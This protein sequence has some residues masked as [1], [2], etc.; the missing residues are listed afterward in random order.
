MSDRDS[1]WQA[2]NL[3]RIFHAG[4]G[5]GRSVC[6]RLAKGQTRSLGD[7]CANGVRRPK[8]STT[9][10]ATLRRHEVV[11][12]HHFATVIGDSHTPQMHQDARGALGSLEN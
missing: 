8:H 12:C 4:I 3:L 2:Q 5:L 1:T 9:P 11:R 6:E 7:L 10:A